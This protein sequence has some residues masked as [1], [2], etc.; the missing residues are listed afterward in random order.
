MAL[1]FEV[2]HT[3][4]MYFLD[5]DQTETLQSQHWNLD[6]RDE[7]ETDHQVH[8]HCYHR[9]TTTVLIFCQVS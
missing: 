3:V 8:R 2:N 7:M 9:P 5:I 6:M 4:H 1:P